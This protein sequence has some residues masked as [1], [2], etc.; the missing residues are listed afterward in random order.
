MSKLSS[1]NTNK[2]IWEIRSQGI[3]PGSYV[4]SSFLQEP[5][6]RLVLSPPVI[7]N[8]DEQLLVTSTAPTMNINDIE[9]VTGVGNN[10]IKYNINISNLTEFYK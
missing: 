10:W 9:F 2:V 7:I 5:Y 4:A 8:S 1:S 6:H 3:T